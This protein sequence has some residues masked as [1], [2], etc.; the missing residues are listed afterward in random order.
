MRSF[1]IHG[2]LKWLVLVT[3]TVIVSGAGQVGA[4]EG[5]AG[6]KWIWYSS[7]PMPASIDFPAGT[8]WFRGGF[9]LPAGAQVASAEL[10]LTAD[11][12]WLVHINGKP[13]A[14]AEMDTNAWSRA[15]RIDVAPLL[16]GGRNVVAIEAVNTAPGPAALL[17]SLQVRLADGTQLAWQTDNSWKCSD[18]EQ[19]DWA[20]PGFDDTTWQAAHVVGD[21]G[22]APWG[23]LAVP[24]KLLP[25]GPFEAAALRRFKQLTAAAIRGGA[26]GPPLPLLRDPDPNEVWPAALV[27]IGDDCSLYRPAA[28]SGTNM[29]SLSVTIFNP[30]HGR[31]YPEHDLPGPVKVGR[32]LMVQRPARPGVEPQLLWDAGQGAIGPPTVSYDGNWIY[33]PMTEAGGAFFHLYRLPAGGG[34][35]ERLTDGPFHDYDPCELP[36]G[37]L[38]FSSTRAGTFEEYHNPPSRPLFTLESDGRI[39]PLTR[40][41]QFD[42]EPRVL[43]DGRLMMLRTDNFF[44]RGKVETLLH[45]IFPDGTGGVTEFGLEQGPEYGNRL[46]AFNVGSPAP[47]PDGRV[48]WV[49]GSAVLIARPGEAAAQ[50]RRLEVAAADVSALPDGRLVCTVVTGE[51]PATA[52]AWPFRALALLDPDAAEPAVVLLHESAGAALHSP[53]F[54]GP[55][56]R[57]PLLAQQVVP[58]TA[59][60]PGQTGVLYCQNI[61]FTRNQTAG[62]SQVRAIRVLA[63]HG[64]TLRSSHSYLVHAGSEVVELG[65]VPIAPDGSFAIEVPADTAIALQAVDAEG[66]SE[67]N[68]M[69]WMYVRPGETRGCVG[70][71]QPRQATPVLS[72]GFLKA[73]A[74]APLKL[75]G[76]GNPPRFRGNNPA[77]TGL[78]ELQFDRFR[79]VAGLNNHGGTPGPGASA[80]DDRAAVIAGLQSADPARQHA[81]AQRA[82]LFRD[83]SAAAALATC[84]RSPDRE[85]RVASAMALAACG[86]GESPTPLTQALTDPDPLVAQA[87]AIAL[88]NLR[89]APLAGFD[90]FASATQRGAWQELEPPP[91]DARWLG[92]RLAE[93]AG[94]DRDSARR[95][96]V[97]L[98]HCGGPPAA[99]GLQEKFLALREVNPFPAWRADG[100]HRGDGARF[101]SLEAVNPRSLQEITRALGTVGGDRVVPLLAATVAANLNPET[102][103]LF[104]A[105]AAV[106]ALA[107]VGSPAAESALLDLLGKLPPYITHS[108][109]YGDHDALIACHAAPVHARLVA[110]LDQLGSRGAGPQV[111]AL[112]RMVPTDPDRA[113]MP[114]ND[115]FETLVGR[116]IR[117]SGR[118][119]A[120]ALTCLQ[121]LGDPAATAP[122]AALL[123]ALGDVQGAWAGHPSR[124]IRAAQILSLLVRDPALAPEVLAAF[125]R[126]RS[127]PNTI[128]RLYDKG[129]PVVDELPARHWVCFYLARTLGQ[130]GNPVA[131]SA[132]CD[133]LAAGLAEAATGRPD[134]LGPGVLFLH[135]DLTPCWRAGAAW[136]LGRIG[137]PQAMPALRGV[138]ANLDNAP[139]TRFAAATALG[140]LAT[141][142]ELPALRELAADVPEVSVRHA[143]LEACARLGEP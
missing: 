33:F 60:Q 105:E 70:C 98:A 138:L 64:L 141:Q 79:E 6:A 80:P 1:P 101:N 85:V 94:D 40:T 115:D 111:P 35:P 10:A 32:K 34:Q 22:M 41:F 122:D 108:R 107:R 121:V 95:A 118:G 46:R 78:M 124:E 130:L 140:R 43:A 90:A 14:N 58:A 44:D 132:L 77:V 66:R 73:L 96:A 137:A 139:D 8:A 97:A 72:G 91:G 56:P 133:S 67:L 12:L 39:L 18:R 23:A 20:Q 110:A 83:P 47:M 59:E 74:A 24:A 9:E 103:N 29:D 88:E 125:L 21:F 28:H 3:V 127:L 27:F 11:N 89:G 106:E 4:A 53:A 76:R 81:A 37:R 134:P 63:G 123:D 113:L 99:A 86:T 129:I 143:L 26:G 7:V 17:A 61:R 126:Y 102:G 119:E 109:W 136:A 13:A 65:T 19:A 25:A 48:A 16:H 93:L 135:N 68:Q 104:L 31:A 69:S 100:G 87:A 2:F 114:A 62:W 75:T 120:L 49:D 55:R 57:P 142:A 82:A 54:L 5:F 30:N 45:A 92:A 131:V 116:V 42:N 128:P 117:R 52:G 50:W 84:L 112:V 38:V 51:P 15:R 71:H 36:D